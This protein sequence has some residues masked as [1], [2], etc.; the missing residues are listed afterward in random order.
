MSWHPSSRRPTP[1]LALKPIQP[2][3][4]PLYQPESFPAKLLEPGLSARHFTAGTSTLH[5]PAAPLQRPLTSALSTPNLR[6][7]PGKP[8]DKFY[9]RVPPI[10]VMSKAG[11]VPL[12]MRAPAL[13]ASR[14][15]V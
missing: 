13:S 10:D 7:T 4:S 3:L 6:G 5:R 8:F 9:D 2:R 15:M 14:H 12:V 11:A 1:M